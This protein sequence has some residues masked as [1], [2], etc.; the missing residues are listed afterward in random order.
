M[1]LL[2]RISNHFHFIRLKTKACKVKLTV[3]KKEDGSFDYKLNG[4]VHTHI[5]DPR[6]VE[7]K[8]RIKA[9][10]NSAETSNK[11]T[12]E[13]YS[14]GLAGMAEQ[15]IGQMPTARAFSKTVRRQRKTN[16][17]TAPKTLND[18]VL[19]EIVTLA[20][21]NFILFDNGVE[22]QDRLIVFGTQQ[23][24]DFM[25]T[26][27]ILHMDGTVSTAPPLFDQ[28]YVIHGNHFVYFLFIF[29]LLFKCLQL[30]V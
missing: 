26:C 27:P 1:I 2:S 8:N 4:A 22:A 9:A 15:A 23:A 18:L 14:D 13:L 3:K 11:T 29:F 21:E 7:V 20:K 10:K 5:V 24:L 30:F 12:R 6:D 16:H 17:P 28:I 25:A 19:P